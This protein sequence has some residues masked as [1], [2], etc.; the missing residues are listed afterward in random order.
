VSESEE[1]TAASVPA[2]PAFDIEKPACFYLGREYDLA[3]RQVLPYRYVMYDAADLT[4]HGVIV[5]MTGSGKT[6][7]GIALLE[8]AAID[9]I[10]CII[11]D[12]KGDLTN[13]LLQFPD[14][15]PTDFLDWLNPEDAKQKKTSREEHAA[16]LSRAWQQGLA[17]SYQETK[18]VGLCRTSS[19][20][21]IYTPGSEAG[22]PVSILGSFKAPPRDI[23]REALNQR[24]DATA[25]AVLGLTGIS[26]DPVQS[27]E[28]ILIA[29]L[30]LHAWSRGQDLDLRQLIT[31][32]QLPPMDQVGAFDIETFYPEK[33]RLKLAVALNNI[34]AS[35]SFSTWI[36]GAP[37]DLSQMVQAGGKPCQLIFYVA[38]LDDTQ[39]MFFV[40][41]LLEEVLNWTRRQTGTTSL[42]ALLYFDEVFGYLPPHPANPPSKVPL[43][44]LL[45]Q[46][47]AFGVGVLLATQN[48]V[49]LDYKA[50][51]NAGTWFVGKLQ[52]EHDKA[53]L[54]DGLEGVAAERGTLS[55]RS[56]LETVISALKKRVF[57]LHN[58]HQPRPVVFQSRWTLSFLR[59]PMTRDQIAV[60]MKPVKES[61]AGLAQPA[62]T[63]SPATKPVV[64]IPLCRRCRAELA[65]G[66]TACPKCGEPLAPALSRSEDQQFR[67]R[68]Q[69]QAVT[70]RLPA[71]PQTPPEL[72]AELRQFYLPLKTSLPAGAELFYQ[73]RVLG[74]AA[75]AFVDRRR[76]LEHS[77]PYRLFAEPPA[78]GQALS[79]MTAETI[80]VPTLDAPPVAK[81]GWAPVPE[82]INNARKLKAL[83]KAFAEYLYGNGRLRLFENR[84][85]GLVSQP[86]EDRQAFLARCQDA[87]A[88][89]AARAYE[90]EKLRYLPKFNALHLPLPDLALPQT[91]GNAEREAD[92]LSWMLT[93]FRLGASVVKAVASSPAIPSPK[94]AALEAE[95]KGK[96]GAL[97]EKWRQI[98]EDHSELLLTPRKVDV[99]VTAFGLAWVP[100]GRVALPA[101]TVQLLPLYR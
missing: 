101:G 53:R 39:R 29:Q 60:L 98:A 11:V 35:P 61:M 1:S 37:L 44:T 57:L 40:T 30:L 67:Q 5:G 58:V 97:Y 68:L 23:P 88:R 65:P 99:Q 72:P 10:P 82:S 71:L 62:A 3:T 28:H 73:P 47:R 20:W 33:D 93:P 81:A 26:A 96:V 13:L 8:E 64:A 34:L 31:Q 55:D 69:Q 25:S 48:P 49:D 18:R 70:A 50:L 27:R 6:G 89:E 54:V 21:R 80:D 32:V 84:K 19:E 83:E 41:L 95:W 75:V 74:F 91:S 7:L 16:E 76:G 46:A 42:R 56:Y 38:H 66:T 22:L 59:G 90:A 78:T 87:A 86:Q 24:I 43:M 12:P 14:L 92:L 52:T 79:W 51:S 45:K 36:T 63:K 94:Q 2:S 4:T 15:A 17:D 100:L 85:L 77:R 9:G